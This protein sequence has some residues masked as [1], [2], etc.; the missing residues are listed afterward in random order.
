MALD[1]PVLPEVRFSPDRATEQDWL[2]RD[3][4]EFASEV[5]QAD[6]TDSHSIDLDAAS[7]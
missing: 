7:G 1:P 4:G 2:L 6:V 3:D 5:G